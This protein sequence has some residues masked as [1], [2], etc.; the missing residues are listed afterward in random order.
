MLPR[1]GLARRTGSG[2]GTRGLIGRQVLRGRLPGVRVWNPGRC[3]RAGDGHSE[4]G[5]IWKNDALVHLLP[6]KFEWSTPWTSASLSTKWIAGKM[7]AL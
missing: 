5:E 7:R 4:G 2:S 3:T 1:A 6:P